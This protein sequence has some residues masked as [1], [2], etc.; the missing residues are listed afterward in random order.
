M[1][2]HRACPL[3]ILALLAVLPA[4]GQ[5]PA[6]QV[7]DINPSQPE[8]IV[9]EPGLE[10]EGVGSLFYFVANDGAHGSEVW[11]TDGTAA[12]TFLLK[13][14]CPGACSPFPRS[15]TG[16]NGLLYF[17]VDGTQGPALWRSDGTPGGTLLVKDDLNAWDGSPLNVRMTDLGGQLLFV[18]EGSDGVLALW[19]TDGTQAGTHAVG[20]NARGF[21][22]A[23]RFLATGGGRALFAAEDASG[24]EPWVTDGTDAG[25]HRVADLNPGAGDS[26]LYYNASPSGSD[27]VAAPWGGFVFV[28]S[29]GTHG[30]ELWRTDGTGPGTSQIKDIATGSANSSPFGLTAVNG[31][32][33]FAATD[34]THGTEIWVTDGTAAGTVPLQDIW[35]GGTSSDPREITAVGGQAFFRASDGTHG[36]ELWAT[37]GTSGGTRMVK[38]LAPGFA[39]GFPPSNMR[40]LFSSVG[41]H[42]VFYSGGTFW[43]SDGTDTGTHQ[44]S[45]SEGYWPNVDI[46][47]SGIDNY[48]V[49][50]GRLFFMAAF[51][52]AVWATDGTT[53]GSVKILDVPL[54]TSAFPVYDGFEVPTAAA[55]LGGAL[56]FQAVDTGDNYELWRSDGTAA[57][58]GLLKDLTGD[59]FPSR[60]ESFHAVNGHLAFTA[61]G[62]Q[63]GLTDGTA[64]G[65][66]VVPGSSVLAFATRPL[67]NQL[68][69][70]SH[71]DSAPQGLWKTDG[72]EAG[73]VLA[74]PL[75]SA[76][77]AGDLVPS[78]GKLFFALFTDTSADL[79]VSDGT[80]PGTLDIGPGLQAQSLTDA[81]GTLYFVAFQPSLFRYT[82]WKSDGTAP[83]TVPVQSS[84]PRVIGGPFAALP[85]GVL[86]F[87]ADDLTHGLELWRTDGTDAG[88]ALVKDI[89]PGARGS[90]L[91]NLTVV[92]SQAFFVADDGVH[93]PELWA[94]DGTAAGTRLVRDIV[95]GKGSSLPYNLTAVG[96]TLVFTAFDPVYGTE[97]WRSDGTTLGTR[98]LADVAPGAL[99]SSPLSYVLSGSNLFFVADDNT[100]GFELWAVP[101]PYVFS[102]F[103]D[104]PT[105]YWAWQYIE[106]L[107]AAGFTQG[108]GDGTYCPDLTLTRAEMAVFLGR[109]LHGVNTV[110]PPATG[111]VFNDVPASYWAAS[112]IELIAGDGITNG[113]SA[114]PPLFCPTAQLTRAEMAV[115]LLRARHGGSYTPPPAT[116]TVFSDVPADY[117]AAPWIEQLAA[118]GITNGCAPGSYCPTNTVTRAETA[119]FLVR[120]FNLPLP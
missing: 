94:S 49:A 22:A 34:S 101:T 43:T 15:L 4:R 29:D 62:T 41:G 39:D 56:L 77:P 63:L 91:S 58:T 50:A 3:A 19:V 111:T 24:W 93:G 97:A 95:P 83:G 53:A 102:T 109:G 23:P 14:V 8:V 51:S 30:L 82:L 119:A 20:N 9:Y 1:R 33:V 52:P 112:W 32:V 55:D 67:G 25:T 60:P 65:T 31:K 98:R 79:W 92:G 71:P 10:S 36:A 105:T 37:D 18:A 27:A 81:N 44:V 42:L 85:G 113:C 88:T 116:G 6:F 106:A 86:L 103:A 2:F 12:G 68:Y 46:F 61:E 35:P 59:S 57:G 100:T 80:G 75:A 16:S 76:N 104:A 69:F 108:C 87:A 54:E 26:V 90:N 64:A 114:S 96:S 120:T 7:K 107:A 45:S 5:A 99:S 84:G 11:R 13:D 48:G 40:Y 21:Y 47:S 66:E 70:L 17:L 89:R 118:E 78:G 115:F 28:A 38:D 110:P 117:W 72:T 74:A 73:T